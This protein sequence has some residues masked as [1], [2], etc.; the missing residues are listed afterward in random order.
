[1]V[2]FLRESKIAMW[3]L[4]VI[5]V[6]LGYLWLNAGWHKLA[7]GGFDASGFMKGAIEKPLTGNFIYSIYNSFLEHVALPGASVFSFLVVWGEVLI[8]LG[9]IFGTFTTVAMF[10]G[11]FMNYMYLFAGTVSTNGAMIL[12]G[13]FVLVGGFNSAKIG[14][15]NW[16]IPY[17]HQLIGK[18]TTNSLT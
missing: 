15:D 16:V 14:L 11:L 10:F 18:K 1:M 5:R 12:L 6:Y 2:K 17:Y 3:I 4:T 8:G 9:L 7:A 13:T